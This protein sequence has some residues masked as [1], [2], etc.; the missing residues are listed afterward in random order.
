MENI[1]KKKNNKTRI[2]TCSFVF[3]IYQ[4]DYFSFSK[5]NK[6]ILLFKVKNGCYE[7]TNIVFLTQ[8]NHLNEMINTF[9]VKRQK[10]INL[11]IMNTITI[12]NNAANYLKEALS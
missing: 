5:E 6:Q 9:Y 4:T 7:F 1:Q 8:N 12:F 10:D 11:L 3:Y 2:L